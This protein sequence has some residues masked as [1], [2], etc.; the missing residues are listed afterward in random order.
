MK[1]IYMQVHVII[2]KNMQSEEYDSHLQLH[3]KLQPV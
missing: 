3:A 1:S 2:V